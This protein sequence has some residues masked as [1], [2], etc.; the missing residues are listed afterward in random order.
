MQSFLFF[1]IFLWRETHR[2]TERWMF[3]KPPDTLSKADGARTASFS[4]SSQRPLEKFSQPVLAEFVFAQT[5][6]RRRSC[7]AELEAKKA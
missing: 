4:L 6:M 7:S 5:K 2:R 3:Q 1:M